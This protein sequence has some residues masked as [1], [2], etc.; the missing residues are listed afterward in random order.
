[1]KETELYEP[2]KNFLIDFIGCSSVYPEILDLDVLGIHGKVDIGVEL[3]TRLTFKL[4]DQ[5]MS[6]KMYV[7][8]MY[9]AFPKTKYIEPVAEDY[10]RQNGIGILTVNKNHRN[11]LECSILLAARFNRHKLRK[12]AGK[13]FS[14][15]D[16]ITEWSHLNTGGS[17][18]GKKLTEYKVTI[19]RI[20]KYLERE[21]RI[22]LS[23]P[24]DKNGEYSIKE[25]KG[26]NDG[27]P[28]YDIRK[29]KHAGDR[30]IDEILENV[31]THYAQ[32]KPSVV[33]TLKA[34]W[35]KWCGISTYNNKRYFRLLDEV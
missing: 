22:D 21:K 3:K 19:N 13:K 17:A 7:D 29:I 28:I 16:Y 20:M 9:I 35:N 1:M 32:P 6:R 27:K 12:R 11:E 26:W 15:R 24:P 4:L 33:A 2:V 23:Y 34:S 30:T 8:Y 14:I 10:C 18:S 25:Y 31:S 5:A